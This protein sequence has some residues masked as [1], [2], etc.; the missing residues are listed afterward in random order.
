A[1]ET[2][3]EVKQ[4][5]LLA[6]T[7]YGSGTPA[8]TLL[9][10]EI[11]Q[12]FAY[13][14]STPI[15]LFLRAQAVRRVDELV[16][17]LWPSS[18]VDL[19]GSVRT[20]LNLPVSDI[21]MVVYQHP[22]APWLKASL[23]EL[24]RELVAREVA[25]PGSVCVLDTATVPVVKF[26]ESVSRIKFDV[27]FN[28]AA[29]GV[30][31]AEMIRAFIRQFPDLPKLVMVLK[32]FLTVQGLNEVYS[33][34]GV[35]SY[36][37]TLMCIGFLQHQAGQNRTYNDHN[38]LGLMLLQFLDYYGRK[39]DFGECAISVLSDS[40]YVEKRFLRQVFGR[41][42]WNSVLSIVDPV[43]PANDIG[44]S[45]YAALQVM[46]QFEEAYGKLSKLVDLDP[47]KIGGSILGSIVEVPPTLV[48]YREWV[49]YNLRRL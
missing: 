21:D 43:N 30:Q 12:F 19:F 9:H 35:S 42:T 33:S 1:C 15:E 29:S 16:L 24:E 38:R 27:A 37:L 46:K 5:W 34:G 6:R 13:I 18:C 3:S 20:G 26:T 48:A 31:A 25:L 40:G 32:Q 23:R 2:E 7:M 36:A 47:T 8:L 28:A 44:R 39:F 14:Q 41:G 22:S 45:S 49:H 10:Q 11:E 17:S 4:P